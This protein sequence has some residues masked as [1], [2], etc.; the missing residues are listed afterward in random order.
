MFL[1]HL[2]FHLEKMI[3]MKLNFLDSMKFMGFSLDSLV[4][5]L[6]NEQLIH[7]RS[8]FGDHANLL[9][10]KGV[11]PY[12]FMDSFDKFKQQQLPP[13][14][15]FFSKL[16]GENILEDDYQKHLERIRNENNRRIP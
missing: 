15:A 10:R 16:N 8:I 6:K 1:F 12:D 13:K 7:T 5:N 11:Y 9:S 4:K 14:E 2:I 3:F